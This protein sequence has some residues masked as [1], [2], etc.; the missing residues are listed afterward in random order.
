MQRQK[1]VTGRPEALTI[2]DVRKI[3]TEVESG[4]FACV[5]L[6]NKGIK[7]QTFYDYIKRHDS[8]FLNGEGEGLSVQLSKAE[9]KGRITQLKEAAENLK[10]ERLFT[11]VTKKTMQKGG[12]KFAE[13]IEEKTIDNTQ[14][15]VAYFNALVKV[16]ELIEGQT[17]KIQGDKENPLNVSVSA[18][19]GL[20]SIYKRMKEDG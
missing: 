14:R 5:V 13:A 2:D 16:N 12:V 6:K 9:K 18:P 4:S 10:R 11:V 19:E 1:K 3:I 8:E 15:D 20:L 7:H 17:L